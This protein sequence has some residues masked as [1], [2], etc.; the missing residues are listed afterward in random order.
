[1][2]IINV[3]LAILVN[4]IGQLKE[5]S[6]SFICSFYRHFWQCNPVKVKGL[7]FVFIL[8]AIVNLFNYGNK[9]FWFYMKIIITLSNIRKTASFQI[10]ILLFTITFHFFHS[11]VW[12]GS[13]YASVPEYVRVHRELWILK[14]SLRVFFLSQNL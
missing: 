5:Y 1:M 8:Q 6:W 9:G 12:Q 4:D 3:I 13:E 2:S 11:L 10:Y 14:N 7:G